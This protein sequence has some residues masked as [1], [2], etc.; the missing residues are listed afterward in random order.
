MSIMKIEEQPVASLESPLN[1]QLTMNYFQKNDTEVMDKQFEETS[2]VRVHTDDGSK[3]H[4]T[5]SHE[6]EK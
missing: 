5:S 1:M 3:H 4:N 2:R 6:Y